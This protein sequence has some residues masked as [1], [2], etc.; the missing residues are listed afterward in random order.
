MDD[1][2]KKL[3]QDDIWNLTP[4]QIDMLINSLEYLFPVRHN[5]NPPTA[6]SPK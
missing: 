2:D 6:H 3:E 4:K 1:K 5:T